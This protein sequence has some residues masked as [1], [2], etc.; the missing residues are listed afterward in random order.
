MPDIFPFL[1]S[2]VSVSGLSGYETP[3]TELIEARWRPLVDEI[4]LSRLGSVHG[5]KK[6]SGAKKSPV[7]LLAAHMD[8]IGMMVT[9]I[10]DGFLRITSI[11][12][13]DA[14]VLPSQPVLV[15]ATGSGGPQDLPAVILLPPAKLLPSGEADGIVAISDLLVD[16]GLLPSKVASLVRIGD[17][18]SF[19]TEAVEISGESLIGHSL[20][21]RASVAAVTLCLQELS[22][23]THSW[24]IWAVATVRE[25]IDMSGA[26]TS[27]F[28]L[29]P[30]LTIAID[31]TFG[32][33][34][35]AND[36]RTFALGKG[37]TLGFGPNNHPFLHNRF[38][39]IA[40]EL[41]IPYA[42]EIMPTSSGTDGMIMQTTAEG[43]PNIVLGIPLRYMHSPV[44]MVMLND[45]QRVGRLL[46]EFVIGLDIDFMNTITWDE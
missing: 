46:A 37:I 8:A 34:P 26:G 16:V 42:T 1:K 21:N 10:D 14:R 22:S 7:I 23:R 35:G 24:D 3:V 27:T 43:V 9:Q 11:G 25:E 33:G 31:V 30:D 28:Q 4:S 36:W 17:L 12:G 32:K 15:H 38:K 13:L 5:L 6:G 41:E 2:L 44:E 20:D 39:E 29:L 19:G 40:E 45:I 18:I